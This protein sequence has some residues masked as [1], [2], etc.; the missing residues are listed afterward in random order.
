L[1]SQQCWASCTPVSSWHFWL[2]G[3]PADSWLRFNLL[4]T[5][6]PRSPLSCTVLLV[7]IWD[8]P[9][10]PG[11]QTPVSF[12]PEHGANQSVSCLGSTQVHITRLTVTDGSIPRSDKAECL[13]HLNQLPL[14]SFNYFLWIG[15]IALQLYFSCQ[16]CSFKCFSF[17]CLRSTVHMTPHKSQNLQLV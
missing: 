4:S 17:K 3:H 11:F 12:K 6:T 9:G 15:L 14:T 16:D 8:S 1:I 7:V 10:P 2:P 5:R 13:F